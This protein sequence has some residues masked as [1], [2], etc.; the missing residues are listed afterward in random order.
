MSE[1]DP[2]IDN[3]GFDYNKDDDDEHQGGNIEMKTFG[4]GERKGSKT[5]ETSFTKGNVDPERANKRKRKK[6]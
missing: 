1:R 5:A 3:D 6:N 2:L 4:K